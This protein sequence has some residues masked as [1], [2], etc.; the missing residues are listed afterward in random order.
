MPAPAAT[1]IQVQLKIA[2]L[3]KGFTKKTYVNGAI[4]EDPTSLPDA[5]QN[6]VDAWSRGDAAWFAQW[7]LAQTA[8]IPVTSTPGTPSTGILP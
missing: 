7:Q 2:L 8:L 4:V 1:S 5:L 6:L 3:A